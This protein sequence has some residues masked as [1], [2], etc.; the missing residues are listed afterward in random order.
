MLILHQTTVSLLTTLLLLAQ[1]K[2]QENFGALIITTFQSFVFG[3]ETDKK[4]RTF[5]IFLRQSEPLNVSM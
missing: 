5:F 4:P 3:P 1:K 2:E